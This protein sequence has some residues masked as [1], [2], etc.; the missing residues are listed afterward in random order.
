ML[1]VSSALL[2]LVNAATFRRERTFFNW[3]AILILLYSGIIGYDSLYIQT[4]DTGIGI[5]GG[6]F[7]TIS[8]THSFNQFI[9]I[10]G[11]IVLLLTAFFLLLGSILL[12][13]FLALSK[14]T[15]SY[16]GRYK[17]QFINKM[18]EQILILEY[19]LIILFSLTICVI[20]L[21][22]S[23]RKLP[24]FLYIDSGSSILFTSVICLDADKLK[25]LKF[26][27][28]ELEKLNPYFVSGF[29]DGEGSF[30]I[31][32]IKNTRWCFY[33]SFE[34]TLSKNDEN[35][36]YRIQ[37]F[38]GLGNI[39]RDIK[40]NKVTYSV[41][42]IKDLTNVIIP[43]FLNYPLLTQKRS[44]FLLLRS[45]IEI[46][47]R[48]E[49]L[50][51][52]GLN[53]IVNIKAS[54]N[55]GLSGF[56]NVLTESFPNVTPVERPVV[57]FTENPN[58]HWLAG[59]VNGEGSFFARIR[60]SLTATAGFTVSLGFTLAQHSRDR[61]LMYSIIKFLGCGNLYETQK[62]AVEIKINKFSDIITK[63]I[64]FFGSVSATRSK[65]IGFSGFLKNSSYH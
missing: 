2:L 11:A 27:N 57:E 46:M 30:G 62:L 38:F 1:F 18:G 43:H 12:I 16:K 41:P 61:Q 39:K 56:S 15:A 60:A 10:I 59:F 50:T 33:P 53:K 65:S 22:L 37:S 47:N 21:G 7:Q 63:V 44:D 34:I 40:N 52:E 42:S 36:L 49:H 28:K 35:L 17:K 58:P 3:L 26:K 55:R 24:F 14:Y 5:Y 45:I 6:L 23:G 51:T 4:L 13:T 32:I 25:Y 8:I 9:G 31:S 29:A 54:M 19:P 20:S 48:K 64:T